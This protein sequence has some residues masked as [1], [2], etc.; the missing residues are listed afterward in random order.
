MQAISEQVFVK[1]FLPNAVNAQSDGR[2]FIIAGAW[3]LEFTADVFG[4]VQSLPGA[5]ADEVLLHEMIHM[6][7]HNFSDYEDP[8]DKSLSFDGADFLTVNGTNVYSAAQSRNLRK[9]HAW[10]V[11]MPAAMLSS[12]PSR[13]AAPVPLPIA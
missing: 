1:P 11:L 3:V 9:D 13:L 4:G 6:L 12:S 10:F 8:A 7:E 2:V 5:R